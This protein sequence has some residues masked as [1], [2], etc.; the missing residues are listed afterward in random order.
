MSLSLNL[1]KNSNVFLRQDMA[2]H[3]SMPNGFV[4]RNICHNIYYQGVRY[5][6]IVGGSATLFLPGRNIFFGITAENKSL[7]YICNNVFFHVEKKNDRY[8]TRNFTTKIMRLWMKQIRTDW[9]NKY[10]QLLLGLE[11]LVELP[12]TGDLYLR[13]GWS[14]VGVT[15]GYNCKRIA[16][17]GTDSWSGKRVWNTRDLSPKRVFCYRYETNK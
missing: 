12:R 16:G 7:N 1:I 3:Y 2:Y 9:E 4:G 10:Q 6:S 15:K 13:S 8:P 5:G 14:E 17:K 11:S